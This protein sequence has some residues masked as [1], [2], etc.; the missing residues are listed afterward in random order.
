M[1]RW[2]EDGRSGLYAEMT[3]RGEAYYGKETRRFQPWHGPLTSM[4]AW[5]GGGGV[6]P[7]RL[8]SGYGHHRYDSCLPSSVSRWR[9]TARTSSP[10]WMTLVCL[11][12][13]PFLPLFLFLVSVFRFSAFSLLFFASFVHVCVSSIQSSTSSSCW[14]ILFF[15]FDSPPSPP[16]CLPACRPAGLPASL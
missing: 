8:M 5:G 13:S 4:R 9:R 7:K 10:F 6:L 11:A 12:F 1:F 15:A 2:I 16:S 3:R 14:W